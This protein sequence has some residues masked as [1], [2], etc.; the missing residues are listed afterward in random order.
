MLSVKTCRSWEKWPWSHFY[1]LPDWM[2]LK[3]HICI[4][5]NGNYSLNNNRY[6][7]DIIIVQCFLIVPVVSSSTIRFVKLKE[8]QN[9][10]AVPGGVQTL[11]IIRIG[12]IECY[13]YEMQ[14]K[15]VPSFTLK[16]FTFPLTFTEASFATTSSTAMWL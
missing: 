11:R 16:L 7:Q 5:G 9:C 12:W 4:G 10:I 14:E 6:S 1:G 13:K 2:L 8:T 15:E 3:L